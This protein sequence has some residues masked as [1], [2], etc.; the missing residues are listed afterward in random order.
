MNHTHRVLDKGESATHEME[1]CVRSSPFVR[2]G[3]DAFI[4]AIASGIF[5]QTEYRSLE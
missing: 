1:A 3:N 5:P 4:A 2:G